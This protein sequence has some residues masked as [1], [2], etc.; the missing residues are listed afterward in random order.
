MELKSSPESEISELLESAGDG[1][2][3]KKP[4][5]RDIGVVTINRCTDGV[6]RRISRWTDGVERGSE[7]E[8]SEL[9]ESAG[10]RWSTEKVRVRDIGV[11]RIS[12][13]TDGVKKQPRIRDIGVV[14][15]NRWTDGV[16]RSQESEISELL[17]SAGG[18]M[19]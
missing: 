15:I 1:W 8:I 17:E 18:R 6:K 11:I 4:R 19:E 10:D 16:E 12:K 3:R 2:S 9:L 13:W 14:K 5:V 7:S